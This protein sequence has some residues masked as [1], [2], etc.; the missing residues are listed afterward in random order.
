M[1]HMQLSLPSIPSSTPAAP[2]PGCA[3]NSST[4]G[5]PADPTDAAAESFDSLLPKNGPADKPA[6]AAD[7]KS[8]SDTEQTAAILTAGFWMPMVP[9]IPKPTTPLGAASAT[10]ECATGSARTAPADR[11]AGGAGLFASTN[12]RAFGAVVQSGIQL[13]M[14][15]VGSDPKKVLSAVPDPT[16]TAT[17]TPTATAEVTPTIPEAPIPAT[18]AADAAASQMAAESTG[19]PVGLPSQIP[20]NVPM[21]AKKGGDAAPII[22]TGKSTKSEVGLSSDSERQVAVATDA[23]GPAV[24]VSA[25]NHSGPDARPA[26]STDLAS[27]VL[28]KDDTDQTARFGSDVARA[29]T[30]LAGGVAHKLA[31]FA[32]EKIAA[33]TG[34]TFQSQKNP[35]SD[36][37]KYFL[38][39]AQKEVATAAATVG[40]GVAK[41]SATMVAAT[42]S[43]RQKSDS[44]NESTTSFVFSAD[45]APTA[46]LTL[47]A[48][49][50]VATVRETM[51]AVISAVD[52]LERRADVQ[53]KSVDLQFH[54]GNEKLGLRVELRD[55]AVHTTFHTE[56][57]EMNSALT[58]EWH[59]VVQPALAR[60]IHLA[61]PVFHSA[62]TSGNAVPA[63]S[64]DSGATA[65]GQGAQQQREQ[66]KA[67]PAF[68][69]ALKREFYESASPEAAPAVSPVSSSSQ[70]LNA[71]A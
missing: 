38:N 7:G 57:S 4:P 27:T 46:T 50:P 69:S 64:A 37:E 62:S 71:L 61:D 70:L 60:E 36:V 48:P 31:N 17:A 11:T 20:G 66:P 67:P 5:T 9:P 68:A 22:S 44:T 53:Q 55:G 59:E 43:A 40:T 24:Q 15:K 28:P 13:V 25:Q 10:I 58:H 19:I 65:F 49:A 33:L 42:T 3:K 52:A 23:N 1:V 29:A 45:P 56:S 8:D 51:A 30:A 16:A 34:T 32:Q 2:K 54:V 47:D 26:E 41:V 14:P 6:K 39:A 12:P 21:P 18:T 35:F 63:A